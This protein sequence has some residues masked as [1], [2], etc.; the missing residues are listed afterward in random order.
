MTMIVT[1]PIGGSGTSRTINLKHG[2]QAGAVDRA[3]LKDYVPFVTVRHHTYSD[4]G[5]DTLA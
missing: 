2:G 4:I 3:A 5:F 1:A